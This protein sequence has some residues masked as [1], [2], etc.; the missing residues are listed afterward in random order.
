MT[1]GLFFPMM[2][3]LMEAMPVLYRKNAKESEH[4]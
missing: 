4:G 3:L 1:I 2:S